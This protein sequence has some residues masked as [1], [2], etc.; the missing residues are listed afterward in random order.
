MD[1]KKLRKRY[2]QILPYLVEAKKNVESALADLPP[3]EFSLETNLKPYTSM[4]RKLENSGEIDPAKLSDLVRGRI[5]YSDQFNADDTMG[6]LQ[7]LFGKSIEDVDDNKHRAPE[8]GLE[9]H[10]II[11]VHLNLN[12]AKFELQ[13]MPAEFKPF[14]EFLHQIYEK[15]RDDKTRSRL[16]DHQKQFLR[17]VHNNT[18][19]KLDREAKSKRQADNE[20]D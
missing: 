18:Y 13:V 9:Y 2:R 6:I 5:F 1:P 19:K 3:S 20:E 10:G 14:K 17:K 7:K 12:G 15:F 11:H 8:H 4:R 16:T